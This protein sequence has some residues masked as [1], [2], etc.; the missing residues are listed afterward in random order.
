MDDINNKKNFVS[1]KSYEAYCASKPYKS[2]LQGNIDE[3]LFDHNKRIKM[4]ETRLDN[5]GK[6]LSKTLE[7][8]DTIS[9]NQDKMLGLIDDMSDTDKMIVDQLNKMQES[10]FKRFI[11][12]SIAVIV[13]AIVLIIGIIL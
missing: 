10:Y 1:A 8:T 11:L 12:L 2:A 7:I 3:K 5:L 4:C 13:L 6:D 9:S